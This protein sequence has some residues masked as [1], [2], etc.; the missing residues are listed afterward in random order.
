[1]KK[2]F[3]IGAIG[4][5]VFT[6][7]VAANKTHNTGIAENYVTTTAGKSNLVA[8]SFWI[9]SMYTGMNLEKTGLSKD[10]FSQACKGYE[11]LLSNNNIHKAGIMTICDFSQCSNKK[12]LYVL[13]LNKGKVL[14]NTYVAHGRNSGNDYATNFSNDNN[15]NESCLGFMVTAETYRGDNGYS[16]RLDGL[17]KGFNDN[18]RTRAIV[19]HGSYYVGKDR[20]V[21]G[22][23]MGRSFGCPAVPASDVKKIINCIKGGTCFFNFYPNQDYVQNSRI[24]NADFI[25]PDVHNLQIASLQLPDT[26]KS[27][28][29]I[30]FN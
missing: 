25:W 23:M 29:S 13:D 9:D 24:L 10:A 27:S 21:N 22:T 16:M 26:L 3:L 28:D 1:M 15:S 14:F 8:T 6:S 30:M 12:R 5:C 18:V 7:F 19:M 17:E 4:I 20:A 2:N 11:Y